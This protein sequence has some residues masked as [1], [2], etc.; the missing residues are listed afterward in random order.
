MPTVIPSDLP[1]I[2]LAVE[3]ELLANGDIGDLSNVYWVSD[4]E[5]P[6]P[7]RTGQRD[8]LLYQ[9][10]D[11]FDG[12]ESSTVV[13]SGRGAA[14][15]SGMRIAVRT[16]LAADRGGTRKDWFIDHEPFVTSLINTLMVFFPEDVN[17]NALTIEGF[18]PTRNTTPDKQ[19]DVLTWG[20]TV[21]SFKFHYTPSVSSVVP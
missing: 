17:G 3:Q 1:T 14:I 11:S 5:E 6:P 20:Y 2:A 9:M 7:G 19:R 12:S 16:S 15:L 13:G 18:V 4:G 21:A 8:V 10:D